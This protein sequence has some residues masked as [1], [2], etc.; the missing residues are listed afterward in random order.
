MQDYD[1]GAMVNNQYFGSTNDQRTTSDASTNNLD[2]STS[3][4]ASSASS[5]FYSSA[6]SLDSASTSSS[7][8]RN[9]G[10]NSG[11][12]NHYHYD[13]SSGS[14]TQVNMLYASDNKKVT[15]DDFELLKVIGKGN[16]AKVMQVRKKDTGK[17]MAMKILNKEALKQR[18]QIEHTKT[19]RRVLETIE[20]PFLVKLL[21]SFQ[22][23]DKLY[24]VMEFINGGEL[25]FHLKRDRRFKQDR[26]RF[27]AAEI[28]LALEHLHSKNIVYRDLK[29]EN[30]LMTKQGHICITDFGLSK[31]NLFNDR[32][33]TFCGTPEVSPPLFF[34]T[35]KKQ[36]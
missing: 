22:T 6:N 4:G 23:A 10:G 19:E 29:P 18:D 33:H 1:I 5:N 15:V 27:Y 17:V 31:D 26:A 36:Q 3:N 12:F 11:S 20:H 8:A 30:I 2:A 16:F 14:N 34:R 32:T 13:L 35:K 7:S 25:F 21:Y 9:I 28:L 24:M